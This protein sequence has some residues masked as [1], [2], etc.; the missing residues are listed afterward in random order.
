MVITPQPATPLAVMPTP[1]LRYP[2]CSHANSA[3]PGVPNHLVR[4]LIPR[5]PRR[6]RNFAT[7]LITM[8]LLAPR[9]APPRTAAPRQGLGA[10]LAQVQKTLIAAA[11][12]SVLS[13]ATT[14]AALADVVNFELKV[15]GSD[16]ATE[17]PAPRLS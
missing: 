15:S 5:K 3:P 9:V 7:K 17:R 11:L 8:V 13:S 4:G 6:D 12:A 1:H 16:R 2:A 10:G 14:P